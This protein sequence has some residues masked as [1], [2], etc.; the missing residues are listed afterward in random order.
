MKDDPNLQARIY[1]CLGN[2]QSTLQNFDDVAI[3]QIIGHFQA[4]TKY[5]PNWYKAFHSWALANYDAAAYYEKT[6]IQP[7]IIGHVVPAIRG[8][9]RSIALSSNQTLQDTL[10]ILTL[11]FKHGPHKEVEAVLQ[12]GFQTVSID[13]WLQVIPQVNIRNIDLKNEKE[14][15][16]SF[17]FVFQFNISYIYLLDNRENSCHQFHR[18]KNDQ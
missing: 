17:L 7:K 14:R 4:A 9:F 18:E 12:E 15:H 1:H 6:G 3:T 16:M 2:W 11:W 10:R 13:T 5:D 8:F